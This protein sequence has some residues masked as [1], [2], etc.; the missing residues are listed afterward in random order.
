[1]LTPD[2]KRLTALHAPYKKH[3]ALALLAMVVTAAT[4]PLLPY[5]LKL[6]LDNGFG[7]KVNF[8][9]WLVPLIVIGIFA[10]RGASTFAS[11]YLMSYVSTRILNELRR[12]MFASM[13]NLPIDFYNTHT[14]GKVINS[15]MFEVQQIIEMVTKVFT[16]IVRSSLTVLGLLAW[17][18][19][20]N[21]VLTLVTLVLL[22]LLTIVVRTTGKR[23]KK[24]NR[25]SLAVNAELT[26]VI[27]ETTRAQQVIK[28]FGGQ[29]YEKSRFE[30]RAEQLRRYSMRMTTTFSA[31]VPI[32]QVIT[33]AAVALVIVMALF[34]SEQG[35][36]TV[37]GFVSF[38]TA[39]LML[40]TPLK[41]LA[42]V[43][44]PLQR[45]M[46]AAEEVF[47]LIDKTPER[48]GGQPLAGR[49]KGRI[50]FRDV[51]F[52]YPGHPEPA[53]QHI[54]LSIAPGQTIAF[55]GM[56]GGGKST[57]VSL[58][59]GFYSASSGEILLDGQNID[60]IALTSLRSQI[61][62]VSQ[63]VVL[64]DDTLAANIAYGDAAPDRQRIEAAAAAAF[65]SDVIDGLPDG[66]ET[67]LGD[68]G[69]RLSGGQRQ[70]VAIA[71]AIY[72][73]AP[74]LIL[75]EATSA[76]D[77][78]AERAVQAALE[79][80]MQGKTTL[81]IAHRLSTI[82]RADRIVVLSHGK[83]METGSHQQLLDA[84]GAY[85]NLHRLQFSQQVA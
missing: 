41:Q 81:V 9:F 25:D 48:T 80:L 56:S 47:L 7:G 21:W 70:R 18:L 43:N 75:D 12:R 28:I 11:S 60:T 37:G 63:Q 59:P 34:Q 6:L 2:L 71:R 32:T 27:E 50:E 10:M 44:G 40:L 52:A 55:V 65:L 78:E 73:D 82:E 72:K 84:N 79:H 66:L 64:F 19:Y 14:V 46:A 20:L 8:S 26:Q 33:A 61:A 38:I 69:S 68:N 31:T 85:A 45:G 42:E 23:L 54:D 4:E 17:L 24:L 16:S 74:I 15:I 1:M 22:P 5:A 76:L 49:S 35:Q 58:L 83:I 39:M 57:L 67:R 30:E 3:L 13:L 51:S 77:T 62:M 53:L 29:D 36:I